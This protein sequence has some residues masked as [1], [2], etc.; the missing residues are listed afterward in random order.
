MYQK[1]RFKYKKAI[2]T[3]G[4]SGIGRAV[5]MRLSSEGADV[6]VVGRNVDSLEHLCKEI[7]AAGGLAKYLI[8]D[9]S[10]Q[11]NRE[12]LCKSISEIWPDKI[13][14]IINAAGLH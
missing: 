5:A 4:S 12:S 8:C 1:M 14:V 2:V 7:L 11:E 3:G 13:D 6:L 9:L 10:N